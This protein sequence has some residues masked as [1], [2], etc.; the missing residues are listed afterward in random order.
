MNLIPLLQN[1]WSGMPIHQRHTFPLAHTKLRGKTPTHSHTQAHCPSYYYSAKPKQWTVLIE[2][3]GQ[4]T[5]LLYCTI[6]L[7]ERGTG[8]DLIG[9]AGLW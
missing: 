3:G 5:S 1:D 9:T 2:L 4:M 8:L 7:S 6:F